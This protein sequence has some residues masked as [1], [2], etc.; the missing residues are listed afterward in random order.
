ETNFFLLTYLR[1]PWCTVPDELVRL[2]CENPRA[3]D[4]GLEPAALRAALSSLSACQSDLFRVA[5]SEFATE[6]GKRIPVEKTCYHL[7]FTPLILE[8]YPQA[9]CLCI[10]R[11]GRDVVLSLKRVGW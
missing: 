11:D 3:S 4:C 6:Q 10:I 1:K 7:P 9:K 2:F 5:L 8:W